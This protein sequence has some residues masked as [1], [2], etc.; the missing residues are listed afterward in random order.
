MKISIAG[1][2]YVGLSI[3]TLLS[4][5]NEVV[6]YD[7][8]DTKIKLVNSRQSPIQDSEI[9]KQFESRRLNLKATSDIKTAF[10]EAEFVVI[11]TPTDYDEK[12]NEFN[13]SSIE[14]VVSKVL[15]CN[16][17]CSIVIKSTIPV[18]Y[19]TKLKKIFN[20]E[21]IFFSPEFLR[22]GT[23]LYDNFYP[24][25]IIIGSENK[26]AKLFYKILSENMKKDSVPVFFMNSEEA[27]AVKLF[28]NTYLAMRISYF[29]ELDSF[30]EKFSLSSKN[31]IN[32]VS[33][34][35]R[36]GDY[37]NNPSFGYGGYCLPKDTKQLLKNY[38]QVPNSI[39]D[40]IVKA[41]S[42]RKDFIA[43]AIIDKNPNTVG[44]FRLVMKEGSD[45]WR[46]SA[47]QGI[48]KRIK[49]K[50]ITVIVY[51]PSYSDKQ[52]FNSDVIKDLEKFKSMS[53]IIVANR[54][55][56]ILSDVEEKIYTRDIFK[57]D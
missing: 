32:G 56:K 7:I 2:G 4:I 36:I 55:D 12:T 54:Y 53:D 14:D 52:F 20:Y 41:N 21:D 45:N 47:V 15:S 26:K 19:T 35:P 42:V 38:D 31:I 44:I 43:Q 17:N 9:Q 51:E 40:S 24:S 13:T 22:E 3:S 27:E 28:A 10:S 39:I 34:D 23:A 11:A 33:F 8:D 57:R 5:S 46:D 29:N 25:R 48:M 18:G 49:A 6:C 37:Y 1:I 16:K 30:C 50:G